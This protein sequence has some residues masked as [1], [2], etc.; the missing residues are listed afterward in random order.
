M[1]LI[2]ACD[3]LLRG[4]FLQAVPKWWRVA[5]DRVLSDVTRALGARH[6]I[7]C[8]FYCGVSYMR[9][10]Y[11]RGALWFAASSNHSAELGGEVKTPPRLSKEGI[12]RRAAVWISVRA[13]VSNTKSYVKLQVVY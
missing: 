6:C 1:P 8:G 9:V 3:V 13:K 2:G 5:S 12:N 11:K 10:W 7:S 4:I